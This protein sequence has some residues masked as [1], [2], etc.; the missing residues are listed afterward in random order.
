M[1]MEDLMNWSGDD[2]KKAPLKKKK[3]GKVAG[4]ISGECKTGKCST[5][6]AK[7]RR[8]KFMTVKVTSPPEKKQTGFENPR[9]MGSSQNSNPGSDLGGINA[10]SEK[11]EKK[12]TSFLKKNNF[13]GK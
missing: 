1:E 7:V 11:G 9:F 2:D 10:G 5:G 13:F 4:G 6:S 8:N 12:R 3:Y